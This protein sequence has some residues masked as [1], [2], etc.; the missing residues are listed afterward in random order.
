MTDLTATNGIVPASGVK[1]QAVT[2]APAS[3]KTEEAKNLYADSATQRYWDSYLVAGTVNNVGAF[4]K[5][6]GLVGGLL[7][8]MGALIAFS[9]S[10]NNPYGSLGQGFMGVGFVAGTAFG[11]GFFVLGVMISAQGQIMMA[12]LDAAVN[13][14]PFLDDM[15]RAKIMSLSAKKKKTV[16]NS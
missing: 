12:T 1:Q 13:S 4:T 11:A 14:S 6:L 2:Q 15:Q 7:V 9:P 16:G 5:G 3:P 8:C 10:P